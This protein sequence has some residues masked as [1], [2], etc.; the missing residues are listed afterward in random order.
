ML[1]LVLEASTTSAKAMLYN[2]DT[3]ESKVLVKTYG[4]M[5]DDVTIHKAEQVFMEMAALGRELAQWQDVSVVSL[6]GTWHSI[7]LCD[8]NISGLTPAR[9]ISAA[10][11]G[12]TRRS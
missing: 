4:K 1:I 7:L 3:H 8:K 12:V 5:Y 9:P 2:S 10:V 11:S 6:S